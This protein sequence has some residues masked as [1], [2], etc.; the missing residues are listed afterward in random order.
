MHN[1]NI[2]AVE[3]AAGQAQADPSS[4]RQ[5]VEL[6]GEWQLAEGAPQFR[7]TIPYP[8][9]ATSRALHELSR[10]IRDAESHADAREALGGRRR[11]R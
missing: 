10:A 3:R 2:E 5:P 1:V 7:A 6:N 9:A 8:S 11:S 4:V